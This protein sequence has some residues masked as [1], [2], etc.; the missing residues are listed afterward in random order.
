[1]AELRK[2]LGD[3]VARANYAGE[4]VIITR[5]GR[6]AAALVSARDLE[7]LER[8]E[9]AEDVRIYDEAVAKD[10]GYRVTHT[11]LVE[12]LGL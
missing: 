2:E 8:F 12:E 3:A 1:M 11:D 7:R 4:R 5:H 10:D 9:E 6:P